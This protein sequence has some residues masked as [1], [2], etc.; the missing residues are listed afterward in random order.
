LK[1]VFRDRQ[2][3]LIP[4]VDRGGSVLVVGL[5]S[6][7]MSAANLLARAGCR[8]EVSEKTEREDF[9]MDLSYLEPA[10]RVHWG[11]HPLELFEGRD[12]VIVSPGV[13]VDLEPLTRAAENGIPVLG[14]MELAFRLTTVPWVAVTGSNGKST[15]VTL[16]DLMAREDDL[17]VSTGGNIGTPVTA[18]VG[19]TVGLDFIIAEVSSFQLETTEM[20][21]P[22]IAAL[23]NLSPDH[24]D[25]YKDEEEYVAAKARIFSA[26]DQNDWAIFNADDPGTLKIVMGAKAD[27]FPFSRLSRPERGAFLEDGWITLSDG[28]H[29]HRIL[30]K[31]S[32]ALAGTHNLENALAA[33]AVAW[34]MGVSPGAMAEVLRTFKGLEHRMELVGYIRGIGIYNDSKGTNVGATLRSLEGF[35]REVTL[36][37]GGKD[38]GTS[39]Q[40]LL[41]PI[42]R[43]VSLL[44]LLGEAADRMEETFRGVTRI[45]R[46]KGVDEAVREAVQFTKPGSKI[47]FSPACSSFDMFSGF[48]ERGWAFKD[49]ARKYME[50]SQ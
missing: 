4:I 5:G 13:P 30:E 31:R 35:G 49:A 38:K 7:G 42:Q 44:I 45:V 9:S 18:F 47:L 34:K 29:E 3:P 2:D 8:V 20:F 33:V 48:E 46:V 26:M 6:S 14:E 11:G 39:Y 32:V 10:V 17:K 37:L 36:I 43:K 1:A 15:T 27:V 16:L 40:P 25:R 19:K 50:I 22:V 12:L 41:E 24:L 28:K 21:Q 23:L